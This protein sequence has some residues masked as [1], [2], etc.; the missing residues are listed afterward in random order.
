MCKDPYTNVYCIFISNIKN[1]KESKCLS[2]GEIVVHP[3]NG[4]LLS[5]KKAPLTHATTWMKLRIIKVGSKRKRNFPGGAVVKNPPA[6]AGDAS[7][8]PG[9]GGSHMLWSN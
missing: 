9:P 5:H 6:N 2:I 7:S 4:I 3:Y 8:S 1:W